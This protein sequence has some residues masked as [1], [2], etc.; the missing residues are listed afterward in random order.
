[1]R[2][3]KLFALLLAVSLLLSLTGCGLFSK[4]V[5]LIVYLDDSLSAAE[6]SALGTQLNQLPSVVKTEFVSREEAFESF[7]NTYENPDAFSGIDAGVLR[8]RYYITAKTRNK[9][10]LILQIQQID[11]VDEVKRVET[12]LFGVGV[13]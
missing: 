6:A 13:S 1:M 8:H 11:G 9:E 3:K 10:A 4:E 12:T 7:M 5:S 2:M